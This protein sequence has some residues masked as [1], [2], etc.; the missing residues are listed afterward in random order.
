MQPRDHVTV[1]QTRVFP[2]RRPMRIEAVGEMGSE[3]G[4]IRLLAC[5]RAAERSLK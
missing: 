2:Q 1:L 4:N 3:H 5:V